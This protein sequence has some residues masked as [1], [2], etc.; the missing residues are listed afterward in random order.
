MSPQTQTSPV[1]LPAGDANAPALIEFLVKESEV[2]TGKPG[3]IF[4][5]AGAERLKYHVYWRDNQFKVK[6]LDGEG[7]AI[8][9]QY[10]PASQF[11]NHSIVEAL[12]HGQLY[13]RSVSAPR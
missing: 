1:T 8:N 3:R 12:L 6:R 4:E 9:T 13:T 11:A 5:I 7:N 2:C 10:I